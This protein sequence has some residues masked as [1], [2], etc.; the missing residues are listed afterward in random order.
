MSD[1]LPGFDSKTFTVM[2]DNL[3]DFDS[4][5]FRAMDSKPTKL[6]L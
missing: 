6:W 2:S 5:A 4:K 3:P 1:N